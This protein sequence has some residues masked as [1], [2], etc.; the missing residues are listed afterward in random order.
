MWLEPL[1]ER[2]QQNR[3]TVVCPIIDIIKAETFEYVSSPIV[4]G[5]FNW[6]LHFKWDSVQPSQLR[7]KED[8]VKPIEYV[9]VLK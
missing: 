1:L 9:N 4:R 3:T 6:G 5:G 2:I 8:T 7:S